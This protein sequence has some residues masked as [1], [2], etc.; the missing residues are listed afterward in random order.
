M[1]GQSLLGGG[2]QEL[3]KDEENDKKKE[4]KE[5][6]LKIICTKLKQATCLKLNG[7]AVSVILMRCQ[8]MENFLFEVKLEVQE[9]ALL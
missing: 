1:R 3:G 4:R 5:R 7:R 2:V 6:S 9:Q 8:M